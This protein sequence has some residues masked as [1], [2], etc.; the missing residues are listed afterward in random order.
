MTQMIGRVLRQPG[1][2]STSLPALN[3]CYVFCFDQEV[4]EAVE[5]VRRGLEEEGMSGLAQE[6]RSLTGEGDHL[7]AVSVPRASRFRNVKIFL[8]KVL[9]REESGLVRE[10]DYERDILGALAWSRLSYTGR[11]RFT[12]DDRDRLER[13]LV[14]VTMANLDGQ[15]AL[16][17]LHPIHKEEEVSSLDLDVPFLVRQLM[18]AVPNPWQAVRIL[19]ETLQALEK[20]GISRERIYLNRLFLLSE[21]RRDLVTQVNEASEALFRAKLSQGDIIFRL[22]STNDPALNWELAETLKLTVRDDERALRR[23]ND[24]PL[25]RALFERVYERD[26]NNLEK[27]VAWYLDDRDAVAWWHRLVAKQDYHLQGWQKYK[28]YPDF[29]T[30]LQSDTRG[31]CTFTVLE[32]KGAQL[33]GN[34]DTAYKA[35]LFDLLGEYYNKSLD[36]GEVE[37]SGTNNQKIVFK[38]VMEDSWRHDV[39]HVHAVLS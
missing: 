2:R 1:A 29:L 38:I 23:R 4:K 34:A 24:E 9:Y 39:T 35:K 7:K 32:T 28:I 5:S 36:A 21:M 25:E 8:P 6:V 22:V 17:P 27:N 31:R 3:E 16:P 30:C 26:F 13:T 10:L 37:V 20:R 19:E 18:E 11:E 14:S 15:L 33:K 12:P